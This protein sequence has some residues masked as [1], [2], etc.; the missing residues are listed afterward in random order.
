MKKVIILFMFLAV[1]VFS[2]QA[3]KVLNYTCRL[4]NGITVKTEQCW[5]QVWVDQRF[6]AAKASD[7]APLI[8]SVRTL[9]DLTSNSAFK[10]YS[11][12]KEV[13]VQ[14]V[15][16]GTYTMKVTFK[17]SGKPGS[18]SFDIDNII[19]KPQTKTT[20]SV[21]LYDYQIL[22]AETPGNLKDLSSF[23]SKVDRYSGNTEQNPTCGVPTFYS[24]G[25]RDKPIEP[26]EITNNKNVKIR[27]GT[28]DV[29]ITLGAP[30][31]TQKVWLE[32]FILKPD[33][34]YNITTNLNAGLVE[35]AGGNRDVKAFHMYPA[36]TADRQKGTATPD[37]NLELIKCESQTSTSACPPGTYDV[38]INLNNGARYEWR[39][40]IV[41]KT[42][43]RTQVK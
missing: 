19:I 7:Q 12:G 25:A 6:D 40:N 23:I 1:M 42:G 41:V 16:P 26:V 14:G 24:K 17:L 8:L 38:L 29:L 30:G 5:N 10:L 20:I 39:K 32:N 21:T 37:K 36:G 9:G 22:I 28:Y 18:L 13:K 43:T 3:Q 34:S 4:D 27:P 15:K 11:S 35:Y 33:V 2:L 31:K